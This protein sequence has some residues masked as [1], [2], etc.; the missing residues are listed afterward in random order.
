MAQK[1]VFCRFTLQ[2]FAPAEGANQRQHRE[3]SLLQ[4][5]IPIIHEGAVPWLEEA[6]LLP[7]NIISVKTAETSAVRVKKK[8]T[9]TVSRHVEVQAFGLFRSDRAVSTFK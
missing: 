9:K 1:A 8:I 7:M 5:V 6:N 3:R 4:G 2:P